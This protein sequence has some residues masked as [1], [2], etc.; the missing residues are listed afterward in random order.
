MAEENGEQKDIQAPGNRLPL[1]AMHQQVLTIPADIPEHL[2]HVGIK[3]LIVCIESL[4]AGIANGTAKKIS[5][6]EAERD[7][8]VP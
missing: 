6:H 4:D 8:P 5:K 2:G 7:L 1:P 3:F